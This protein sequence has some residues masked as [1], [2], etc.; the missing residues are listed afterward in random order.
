MTPAG[1]AEVERRRK[2]GRWDEAYDSSARITMPDDLRAAL[3]KN[4][5][6]KTLFKSL[7]SRNR[8]AAILF[9]IHTVKED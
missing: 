1:L 7:D 2:D 3:D 9:R 5:P 6:A 8:Y 4:A